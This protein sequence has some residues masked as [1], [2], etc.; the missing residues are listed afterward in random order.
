MQ[1]KTLLLASTIIA[2]LLLGVV[3]FSA[4]SQKSPTSPYSSNNPGPAYSLVPQENPNSLSSKDEFK[5][6]CQTEFTV[7]YNTLLDLLKLVNVIVTCDS[8][9]LV[10]PVNS[11]PNLVTIIGSV[12]QGLSRTEGRVTYL[13]FLPDGL[14]FLKPLELHY[15]SPSPEGKE[16]KFYWY[17]PLSGTWKL[18]QAAK[19]KNGKVVFYIYHFSKYKVVDGSTSNGSERY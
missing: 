14:I 7:E 10:L 11:V 3:I 5:V 16:V 19:V 8:S 12:E 9:K 15:R 18:K 17:D 4:C 2:V 13:D 1:K 6:L